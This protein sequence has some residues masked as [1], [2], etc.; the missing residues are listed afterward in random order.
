MN[1]FFFV[2]ET[3]GDYDYTFIVVNKEGWTTDIDVIQ[4]TQLN[5]ERK[6]IKT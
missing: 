5:M 4:P 3:N 2:N 6:E 1:K